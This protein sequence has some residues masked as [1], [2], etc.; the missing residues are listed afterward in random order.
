MKSRTYIILICII[1]ACN[2]DDNPAVFD[3]PVIEAFLFSNEPIDDIKL[4]TTVPLEYAD[5]TGSPITDARVVLIKKNQIYQ[6]EPSQEAGFYFYPGNDL[7]VETDD[8]FRLE[9]EWKGQL[10]F[11][12]TVVPPPSEGVA[13]DTELIEIPIITGPQILQLIGRMEIN[14]T[15]ENP[16]E[17]LHFVL[18][19]NIEPTADLEFILPEMVQNIAA[20]F[21]VI[22]AP[23][24]E[25]THTINVL[26]LQYL[27]THRVRVYRV[28]RE[29]ADLYTSR[30]QDSRDLNEPA[31]N[32]INGI[33]IFSA[34]NSDSVFFEVKRR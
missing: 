3:P 11:G 6:L 20:R 2:F 23:T 15:W 22:S 25:T 1:S 16:N 8:L 21:R 27:G 29:Y 19:E 33:G 26:S 30:A 28:N 12:E 24:V 7:T 10:S 18:L 17:E 9:V 5:S 31:S 13:I 32:I 34:F 4:T 14:F